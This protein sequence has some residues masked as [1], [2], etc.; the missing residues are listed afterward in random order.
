[1]H[2]VPLGALGRSEFVAT[3]PADALGESSDVTQASGHPFAPEEAGSRFKR[4]RPRNKLLVEGAVEDPDEQVAK[5]KN[6]SP[7]LGA[8]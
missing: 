6:G 5:D 2:A 7:G 4:L 1:M 3:A 8:G